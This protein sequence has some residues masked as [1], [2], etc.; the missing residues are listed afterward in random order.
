MPTF[1]QTPPVP[2]PLK[3][4]RKRWTRSE[5][6]ALEESGILAGQH[7]ELVE[8]ERIDKMGKKRPHG[9]SLTLLAD[10]FEE[11]FRAQVRSAGSV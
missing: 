8:G 2:T 1:T 9:N 3:P 11:G 4:P 10:W 5:C 7:L 6:A